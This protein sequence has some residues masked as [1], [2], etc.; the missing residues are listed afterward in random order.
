MGCVLSGVMG[1]C[2]ICTCNKYSPLCVSVKLFFVLFLHAVFLCG[3]GVLQSWHYRG[4]SK[5]GGPTYF[6]RKRSII[7]H[8]S[9]RSKYTKKSDR[10]KRNDFII[11]SRRSK[12]FWKSKK[13]FFG[14]LKNPKKGRPPRPDVDFIED[15]Q[16]K[17]S[18][19]LRPPRPVFE[20]IEEKHGI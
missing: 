15:S 2:I 5:V 20:I 19:G 9:K 16:K 13:V 17:K 6:P 18:T 7:K 8:W 14:K 10:L 1:S 12:K 4:Y 3:F 11:R